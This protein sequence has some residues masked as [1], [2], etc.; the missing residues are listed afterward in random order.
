MKTPQDQKIKVYLSLFFIFA[1]L[2]NLFMSYTFNT[3][4]ISQITFCAGV[5]GI[6][7]GLVALFASLF[8]PY[9]VKEG[10]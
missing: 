9:P 5:L 3:E 10:K 8:L 6:A 2:F 7:G 4:I 1:G